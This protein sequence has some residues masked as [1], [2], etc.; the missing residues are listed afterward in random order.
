[1]AL[2][3]F[4]EAS[5]V[6]CY[7]ALGREVQVDAIVRRCRADGKAVAVPAWRREAGRYGLARLDG[8]TPLAAGGLGI[9][10]P[11]SPEWIDSVD[12]VVVPGIAFDPGGGRLG[13]G[14]GWYDRLFAELGPGPARIAV[15][16]DFQVVAR[17]PVEASDELVDAVVTEKRLLRCGS[18]A[19]EW[20]QEGA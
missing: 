19:A 12:M 1:M 3:C 2:R 4:A 14:G 7:M 16:F 9:L 15:A 13:Y 8:D 20:I 5:A 17:V 10:E 11:A 6:A 18:R